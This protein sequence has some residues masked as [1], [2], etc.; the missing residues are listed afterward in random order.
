MIKSGIS[1]K[2]TC[3]FCRE[4]QIFT[5][6]GR[7]KLT[8]KRVEANDPVALCKQG[9]E[10]CDKGNFCRAFDLYAKAADLGD[11]HA[12]FSLAGIYLNGDGVEEDEGKLV[13]HLEEAAIAGHPDARNDLGFHES[14][15]GNFAREQRN[16]ISSLPIREMMAQPKC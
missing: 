2:Q 5:S 3:P 11:A 8:I 15:Y 1:V 14:N 16:T 7:H 6:E 12:H 9:T 4:P 10:E 13:Y